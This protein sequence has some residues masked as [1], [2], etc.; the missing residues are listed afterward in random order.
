[1]K[2][3]SSDVVVIGAG[4]AGAAAS[5]RLS[6]H[7]FSV[8]CLEQGDWVDNND[9]PSRH[10]DWEITRQQQWHPNPNVRCA[11][12]DY[13]VNDSASPIRPLMFN[14]VGGSTVMWSCHMPRFHACDFTMFRDDGVGDDWPIRLNDLAPYYRLNERM[15]GVAGV[16]GRHTHDPVSDPIVRTPPLPMGVPGDRLANAFA[17]LGW[18]WWPADLAIHTGADLPDRLACNHCGPCELHCARRAKASADLR[19]WPQALKQGVDLRTGSRVNRIAV[20]HDNCIDHVVYTDRQGCNQIIRCSSVFLAANG[21]GSPRLLLMSATRGH[22]NG[23][24]NGSGLVGR[25]LMLHPLARVTG[26]FDQPIHGYRGITAGSWVSHHFY[27]TDEQRGFVRGIKLQ[28]LGSTGPALI[29]QGSHG[30]RVAWGRT[31]HQEFGNWFNRSF[32]LSICADDLPDARNRIELDHNRTDSD[33]IPGV[34]MI[35]SVGDNTRSAL[36]FGIARATEAMRQAGAVELKTM[37]LVA[38]AG[39]HLMGTCK[40][41]D[42]PGSSVVSP[43]GETHDVRG[44]YVVDGSAFVTAAAVNPTNTLQALALRAA[45]SLNST[46]ASR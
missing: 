3:D 33:G 8:V 11:A 35:Y 46:R 40:M 28:S 2:R 17:Q 38:D 41:G 36:D 21:I 27:Q 18:S 30:E 31:H 42:D 1:M 16:V 22:A 10:S 14:G 4:A 5:W 37:P 43:T 44:L 23:L 25:R 12:P 45:D 20:R 13:P 19:Y 29:A 34:K 26:R 32:S 7:G 9:S 39:F 15:M 24:A 6:Q